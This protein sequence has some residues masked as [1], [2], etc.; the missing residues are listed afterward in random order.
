M[1]AYD[2]LSGRT[3]LSFPQITR[4]DQGV[5]RVVVMSLVGLGAVGE[6]LTTAETSFQ[7]DIIGKW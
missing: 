6:S 1:T 5:Y 4:A 7:V 3:S 2:R